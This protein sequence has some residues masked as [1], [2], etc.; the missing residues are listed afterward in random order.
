MKFE[1]KKYSRQSKDLL[2]Q[3]IIHIR[4][5]D[6]FHLVTQIYTKT[7]VCYPLKVSP[8]QWSTFSSYIVL[9]FPP[10]ITRANLISPFFID[11]LKSKKSFQKPKSIRKIQFNL[12]S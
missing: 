10:S 3:Y 12:S 2:Y 5:I 6:I 8:F 9:A 4:V 1:Q 11:Y 7:N